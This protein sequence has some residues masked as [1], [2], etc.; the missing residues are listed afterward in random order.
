MGA[1][2]SGEG[3]DE[4]DLRKMLLLSAEEITPRAS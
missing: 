4:E 2:Y 3:K 1:M